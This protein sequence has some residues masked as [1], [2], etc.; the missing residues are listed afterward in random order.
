MRLN[1]LSLPIDCSIRHD[2]PVAGSA[3]IA[4]GVVAFVRHCGSGRDVRSEPEKQP[5]SQAVARL[6]ASQ[7]E[8]EWLTIKVGLEVDLGREAA[9]R[10]A[11]GLVLFSPGV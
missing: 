8:G 10:A 2:A 7:M 3:S 6:A 11:G 9:T 5:K 1:R 4:P